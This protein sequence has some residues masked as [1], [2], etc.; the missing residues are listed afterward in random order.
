[1]KLTRSDDHEA[2][3][4]SWVDEHGSFREVPRSID[5][6]VDVLSIHTD[7]ALSL[8]PGRFHI[9]FV[10]RLV[11]GVS[12]AEFILP[13]DVVL[14]EINGGEK[15]DLMVPIMVG[16]VVRVSKS[17]NVGGN[18][19]QHYVEI[20]GEDL[21]RW[22]YVTRVMYWAYA[23]VG[24]SSGIKELA[25]RKLIMV[26]SEGV[27]NQSPASVD[28]LRNIL[29]NFIG[30]MI[31]RIAEVFQF[32]PVPTLSTQAQRKNREPVLGL[33]ERYAKAESLADYSGSPS[34]L[35]ESHTM[36]RLS[37]FWSDTTAAGG[38]ALYYRRP[39][40][41]SDDW[42]GFEL[43]DHPKDNDTRILHSVYDAEIVRQNLGRSDEQFYNFISFIPDIPSADT[44]VKKIAFANYIRLNPSSIKDRGVRQLFISSSIYMRGEIQDGE[45]TWY[46]MGVF[47]AAMRDGEVLVREAENDVPFNQ[48]S[49]AL[50]PV[51][52]N[53][54]ET[55]VLSQEWVD[56]AWRWYSMLDR[57]QSGTI[58]IQGRTTIRVGNQ[59]DFVSETQKIFAEPFRLYVC[60]VSHD[61][62]PERGTFLTTLRLDRGQP[63]DP[64]KFIKP[65]HPGKDTP[66]IANLK[67][68]KEAG[69]F[70]NREQLSKQPLKQELEI[71]G[72]T[73]GGQPIIQ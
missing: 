37:E 58:T 26:P 17:T 22:L 18:N 5:L 66:D 30:K 50:R 6:S 14:I 55:S 53:T 52:T 39:P 21:S 36:E 68:E 48:T 65:V 57:Y 64:A 54:G 67:A 73:I 63:S 11:R 41:D 60:G 3:L 40:F 10:D 71:E 49:G 70:N 13:N 33:G 42:Y 31:P 25:L 34:N 8:A 24:A 23:N 27:V 59:L 19:V 44:D 9:R 15:N 1:M 28:I 43:A 51:I 61:Y 20:S 47:D 12:L 7:K 32:I 35:L 69:E 62:D 45:L 46:N 4:Q 2:E 29:F 56:T 72:G 38:F 16:A